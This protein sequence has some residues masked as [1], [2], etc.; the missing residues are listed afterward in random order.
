MGLGGDRSPQGVGTD[1][2]GIAKATRV[3]GCIEVGFQEWWFG[4][5]RAGE[6]LRG[7]GHI[8][9]LPRW[10]LGPHTGHSVVQVLSKL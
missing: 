6:D 1:E 5:E 4:S 9:P 7:Q 2:A 10:P 3:A 8:C